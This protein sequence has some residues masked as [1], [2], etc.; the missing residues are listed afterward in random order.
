MKPDWAWVRV[1]SVTPS[2]DH[3]ITGK[4]GKTYLPD[5]VP[6]KSLIINFPGERILQTSRIQEASKDQARI[7]VK[8]K[9]SIYEL[10]LCKED[11]E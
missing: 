8:T 3:L 4:K 5:I 9:N 2:D 6:G 11:D 10:E 1:I 7:T